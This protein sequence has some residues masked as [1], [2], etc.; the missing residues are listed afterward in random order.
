MTPEEYMEATGGTAK[1]F[2][3]PQT[4]F[5]HDMD[6]L[7]ASLGLV[8]EAAETADSFKRYLYYGKKIDVTNL[9]EEAGDLLWYLFLM[10]RTIGSS[11]DEVSNMNVNKLKERYPQGFNKDKANNRNLKKERETLENTSTHGSNGARLHQ[12]PLRDEKMTAGEWAEKIGIADR[13]FRDRLNN[14]GNIPEIY[15]VTMPDNIK[16]IANGKAA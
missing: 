9:K 16:E 8:T 7:H 14:Y 2:L 6:L 13:T 10:L 5:P 12:H 3:E 1:Q 11:F 4:L 15:M